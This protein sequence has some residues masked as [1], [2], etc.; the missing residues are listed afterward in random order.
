MQS[1]FPGLCHLAACNVVRYVLT[2][3]I[4]RFLKSSVRDPNELINTFLTLVEVIEVKVIFMHG[5]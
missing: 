2:T 3:S 4:V 5:T 1:F